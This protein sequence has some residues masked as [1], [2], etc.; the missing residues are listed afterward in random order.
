MYRLYLILLGGW[1]LTSIFMVDNPTTP[2]AWTAEPSYRGITKFTNHKM[3]ITISAMKELRGHLRF[4]QM[5]FHCSK[6]QGRTFHVTT[7]AN[8]SGEAVVEYFSNQTNT[9][10][11]SCLSF[12]RMKDDNSYLSRNCSRWGYDGSSNFVGKW[13][14]KNKQGGRRLHDLTAVLGEHY[15][16]KT[17]GIH[18]LCDDNK[19]ELK[20]FINLSKGDFWKI[21][22]R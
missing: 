11:D 8:S 20:N 15:R 4:T 18:R 6:Q 5:R 19:N 9:R 1:L 16:W 2:P 13:G 3:G 10:P 21:F 14:H 22:V 17:T 7:A 12:V